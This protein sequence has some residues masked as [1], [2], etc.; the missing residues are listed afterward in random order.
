MT[1]IA[2]SQINLDK[3]ITRNRII[4]LGLL[5]VFLLSVGLAFYYYDKLKVS[6]TKLNETVLELEE[7][8]ATNKD[9]QKTIALQDSLNEI[10]TK[11]DEAIKLLGVLLADSDMNSS[12][13]EYTS[14]YILK[15]LT[16]LAA[17]EKEK[18][19]KNN[20]NRAA[21]I[22]GLY[23]SSESKRRSATNELV[24]EY[25]DDKKLVKELLKSVMNENHF[26]NGILN[27][28]YSNSY[29]AVLYIL[30]KLSSTSLRREKD[31]IENFKME[32]EKAALYGESTQ[33]KFKDIS[34]K[35]KNPRG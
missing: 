11:Q 16:T 32:M 31:T 17:K 4:S 29:Y 21:A 23:S 1:T 8:I 14:E 20:E 28:K 15:N 5:L 34:K 12:R 22:K 24:R 7:T 25:G 10:K 33:N 3:Q 18:I 13:K 35:I 19:N 6:E 2:Q 30:T 26:K 27:E 9:L